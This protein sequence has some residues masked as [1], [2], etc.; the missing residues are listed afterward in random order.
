[1]NLLEN[2]LSIALSNS[3]SDEAGAV[4]TDL[5]EVGLDAILDDGM[6]K[7]VKEKNKKSDISETMTKSVKRFDRI[8]AAL[9]NNLNT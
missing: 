6:L 4:A 2:N 8:Q 9:Y 5:L 7:D 3:I 1:M